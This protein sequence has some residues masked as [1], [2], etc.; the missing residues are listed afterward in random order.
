MKFNFKLFLLIN[1]FLYLCN[2][3][4][5]AMLEN[6]IEATD[7]LSVR[8]QLQLRVCPLTLEQ[9]IQKHYPIIFKDTVGVEP[10][11]LILRCSQNSS[12]LGDLSDNSPH[13]DISNSS[14]VS[15]MEK[16][17]M[18]NI[19][20]NPTYIKQFLSEIQFQKKMMKDI[21]FTWLWIM[22]LRFSA[23]ISTIEQPEKDFYQ[24]VTIRELYSNLLEYD[25]WKNH[26]SSLRAVKG[27]E[28][29]KLKI[30]SQYN[31]AYLS[32]SNFNEINNTMDKYLSP[33]ILCPV[34]GTGNFGICFLIKAY[35]HNIFPIGLPVKK[36]T[37]HGVRLS[38]IGYG[39]HDIAHAELDPRRNN[40]R[41]HI[42]MR[43]EDYYKQGF[44]IKEILKVYPLVAARKYQ[45]LMMCF[46]KIY[47][48][49][50]TQFLP[51]VGVKEFKKAMVGF[52]QI[53]H[54]TPNFPAIIYEMND[55]DEIFKLITKL[56]NENIVN[57][58]PFFTSP[59]HDGATPMSDKEITSWVIQNKKVEEAQEHWPTPFGSTQRN[60]SSLGNAINYSKV[61]R[62][63]RFINV[64]LVLKNGEELTYAFSTLYYEWT[65]LNDG[66]K[67]LKFAGFPIK[68]PS[69]E[70][71]IHHRHI[72]C[73]II[74]D[75]ENNLQECVNYFCNVAMFLSHLYSHETGN[76]LDQRYW[77]WH[78]KQEQEL[79][80]KFSC[81]KN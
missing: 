51:R 68:K 35:I 39:A 8:T 77:R 19:E 21:S 62:S 10:A 60:L 73:K 54:E 66:I 58:D 20:K 48:S 37:V 53:I 34:L 28:V 36:H 29:K 7:T 56:P 43:V 41:D 42:I 24:N 55:L 57:R 40:L 75:I 71:P 72:A 2:Y 69:L 9:S 17:F 67:R 6:K 16:F 81:A 13:L 74:T 23:S 5:A 80:Q 47:Q 49:L 25:A 79:T 33:D 65:N 27:C 59:L 38:S 76:S 63:N 52:F 18:A 1:P 45:A 11:T 14:Y 22:S 4:L 44:E 12:L 50:V 30:A 15:H 26:T 3:T 70:G 46:K 31:G 32:L 64:R 61:T 78:F